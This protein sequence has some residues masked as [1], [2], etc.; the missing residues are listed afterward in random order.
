MSWMRRCSS[1]LSARSSARVPK[2][3]GDAGTGGVG[4]PAPTAASAGDPR[5]GST[6]GS[7]AHS[8]TGRCC[9]AAGG[10]RS[11]TSAAT[12]SGATSQ[13]RRWRRRSGRRHP[14]G[15]V[16][17]GSRSGASIAGIDVV[18]I[19]SETVTPPSTPGAAPGSP[20]GASSGP[21]AEEPSAPG[22]EVVGS[23]GASGL[24]ASAASAGEEDGSRAGAGAGAGL[25][26]KRSRR[27]RTGAGGRSAGAAAPGSRRASF[28][29]P[30]PSAPEA[31]ADPSLGDASGTV[32]SGGRDARSPVSSPAGPPAPPGPSGGC[33]SAPSRG[34]TSGRSGPDVMP[35]SIGSRPWGPPRRTPAEKPYGFP[36][37]SYRY[38][39][40]G[41]DPWL[42]VVT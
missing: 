5:S 18:S 15:S 9:G 39:F 11:T 3:G 12:L 22:D 37:N 20:A 21:R 30:V 17:G 6:P 31:G 35:R 16:N 8:Q 23:A 7:S 36:E 19:R 2:R 28:S 32:A 25:S 24:R 4:G 38:P 34:G 29:T 41:K 1:R 14:G 27:A 40:R 26:Q 42:I 10:S 13:N 33:P